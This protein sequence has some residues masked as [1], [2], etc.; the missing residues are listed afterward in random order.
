MEKN[1]SRWRTPDLPPQNCLGDDGDSQLREGKHDGEKR[2]GLC[3]NVTE[4]VL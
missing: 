1:E 2:I 3:S 4:Y